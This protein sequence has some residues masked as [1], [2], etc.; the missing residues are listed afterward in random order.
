MADQATESAVPRPLLLAAH[1][2]AGVAA[3][4]ILAWGL[5]LRPSFMGAVPAAFAVAPIAVALVATLIALTPLVI[6]AAPG[7]TVAAIG[8]VAFVAAQQTPAARESF[9][10]LNL[11]VILGALGVA[12]VLGGALLALGSEVAEFRLVIA[13]GIAAGVLLRPA[14]IY[15]VLRWSEST[16]VTADPNI[17]LAYAI[18]TVLIVVA[19]IHG[20]AVRRG[21]RAAGGGATESPAPG[22]RRIVLLALVTAGAVAV[23]TLPLAVNLVAA[24]VLATAVAL[25]LVSLA[26]WWA[27][28]E[29]VRWVLTALA[30]GLALPYVLQLSIMATPALALGT[31]VGGVVAGTMLVRSA[32]RTVPWAAAG[33]VAAALMLVL[34]NPRIAL[35]VPVWLV[36]PV[37]VGGTALALGGGL[38]RLAGHAEGRHDPPTFVGTGVSG[39]AAVLVAGQVSAPLVFRTLP[40]MRFLG[41]PMIL[42]LVAMLLM[43]IHGRERAR[44]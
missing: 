16:G 4:L 35:G 29:A 18:A 6:R 33:L 21:T 43:V 10:D 15:G 31:V 44:G 7:W 41:V 38:A 12:V 19:G 22:V 32:D 20:L 5:S 23:A 17:V 37:L 27:G 36:V 42:L 9:E 26:R 1:A 34:T 28:T 2:V 14:A 13:A 25:V 3:G 40:D 24:I 11:W 30:V 39:F 8:A